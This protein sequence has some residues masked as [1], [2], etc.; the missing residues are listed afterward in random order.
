MAETDLCPKHKEGNNL[1]E[2]KYRRTDPSSTLITLDQLS[3]TIEVMTNVVNRLREHLSEQV[4]QN[5]SH[6][7]K[8]SED[9]SEG[10]D[11]SAVKETKTSVALVAQ[12]LSETIQKINEKSIVIELRNESYAKKDDDPTTLH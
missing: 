4:L 1:K 10:K 7:T 5:T 3:Q 8:N 2:K 9:N 11:L 12:E 6:D